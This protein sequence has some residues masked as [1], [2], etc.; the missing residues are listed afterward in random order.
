MGGPHKKDLVFWGLYWGPP[1]LGNYHI[2]PPGKMQGNVGTG[3]IKSIS[4][5]CRDHR[6]GMM[7]KLIEPVLLPSAVSTW[8]YTEN[9]ET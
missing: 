2:Q 4:R 9:P 3:S 1:I 8:P 6:N 7:A 5:G